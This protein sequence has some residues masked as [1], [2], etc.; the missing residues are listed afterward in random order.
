MGDLAM[1]VMG[2]R[3]VEQFNDDVI[4]AEGLASRCYELVSQGIAQ[5]EGALEVFHY[6]CFRHRGT[7]RQVEVRI[8]SGPMFWDAAEDADLVE[9][10]AR[11]TGLGK[12]EVKRRLERVCGE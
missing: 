11:R 7:G 6:A 4:K 12:R 8:E 9:S 10:V 2:Q 5:D 3:F 1:M